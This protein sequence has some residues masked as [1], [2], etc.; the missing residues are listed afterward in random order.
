MP[1]HASPIPF[2]TSRVSPKPFRTVVHG[3]DADMQSGASLPLVRISSTHS[4]PGA[5]LFKISI[6]R[7]LRRDIC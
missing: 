4:L 7:S 6:E 3:G 2:V 5:I 1:K